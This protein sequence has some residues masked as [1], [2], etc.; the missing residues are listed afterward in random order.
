MG[1]G[2]ARDEK[3]RGGAFGFGIDDVVV[4]AYLWLEEN[5]ED[6]DEVFVFGFS[7]GAY[8][9]SGLNLTLDARA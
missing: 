9:A 3:L 6:G 2:T 5:Y 1:V 4:A 7:R 8:T